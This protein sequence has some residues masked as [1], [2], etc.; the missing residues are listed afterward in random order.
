MP[1]STALGVLT[2]P[3]SSRGHDYADV[4]PPGAQSLKAGPILG[5]QRLK[6]EGGGVVRVN[7]GPQGGPCP[8]LW[9]L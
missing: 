3:A 8:H 9:T 5:S 2:P 4:Q 1:T 7:H 6:I